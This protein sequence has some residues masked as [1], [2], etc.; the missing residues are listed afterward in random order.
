MD[1]LK[2]SISRLALK[3]SVDSELDGKPHINEDEY[4]DFR[5]DDIEDP[6][7]WSKA[8]K[9][10]ITAVVMFV[11]MNGN[12][13]SSITAGTTKSLTED[14]DISPVAAQLPMTLFLLG[15]CAGP[16][17][18]G[19]LSEFYGRRWI[20]YIT[21]LLYLCFTCLTAWP[22]NFGS[23]L[24]GRFLAACFASGPATIAPAI[25]VD[26]WDKCE[27]CKPMSILCCGGWVGPALGT[28]ISG[29]LQL[30]RDWRWGIYVCLWL[31]AFS[32]P[33]MLTIPETHSPTIL[34][35][36]ASQCR[37]QGHD[38]HSEGEASKPKLLQLYKIAL[39]RPWI[40]LFDIISFLCCLYFCVIFALQFMLFSI[41]PIVFRDMRGWNAG[42]SQLPI[43]GQI[44]GPI[45]GLFIT[46]EYSSR[47]KKKAD[48]GKDMAPEDHM[49]LAMVGG[50]GFP[51]F[52]LWLSWSAQ[53][54]SVHWIV[55][56]IGGTLLST[57][58]FLI[59]VACFSYIVDTYADYAASV[60]A[61]N[62]VAR[63]ASSAGAPLFTTQMFNALGIGGGGSLIAGVGTLLAVT[64]FLF[65]HYGHKIRA[66]SK[67]AQS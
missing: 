64:P 37:E 14:F 36:R 30:K 31:G 8:R 57:S 22:P 11:S 58:L 17:I 60:M 51:I 26:L 46:F 42:V 9:W 2:R 25:L 52:M 56:T 61:A 1:L 45:I 50:V 47:R 62:M 32:I 29:F 13:S 53:Y 55:P 12:I 10:Y 63:C 27:R 4:V 7:N 20:F 39:T 41:F 23:L 16:L 34:T 49:V 59:H 6:T 66:K 19:T 15:Y 3:P 35:Q 43:L 67:Y 18:F 48:L 28:V 38:V 21:F 54:N 33:L 40:M 65:Y 44:I 5:S 24:V